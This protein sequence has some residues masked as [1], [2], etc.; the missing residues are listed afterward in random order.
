MANIDKQEIARLPIKQESNFTFEFSEDGWYVPIKRIWNRKEMDRVCFRIIEGDREN[1]FECGTKLAEKIQE[2][3][4]EV[5]KADGVD[6][7]KVEYLDIS[8]VRKG[9]D[10]PRIFVNIDKLPRAPKLTKWDKVWLSIRDVFRG[11]NGI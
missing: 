8:I 7:S 9:T 4:D 10:E 11:K 2:T 1:W 5:L 6:V 3:V